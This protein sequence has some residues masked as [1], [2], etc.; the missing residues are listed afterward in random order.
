MSLFINLSFK[1]IF[2]PLVSHKT[3]QSI[4]I[5]IYDCVETN[6]NNEVCK[7]WPKLSFNVYTFERFPLGINDCL[8]TFQFE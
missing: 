6:D 7:E 8:N 2:R 3:G 5:R 4:G 1:R